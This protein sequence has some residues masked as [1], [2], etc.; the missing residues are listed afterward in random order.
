LSG[1]AEWRSGNPTNFALPPPVLQSMA[2]IVPEPDPC[3]CEGRRYALQRRG[4]AAKTSIQQ[5]GQRRLGVVAM[6]RLVLCFD[7]TWNAVVSPKTVTNVVRL[8]NLVTV[9]DENGIDQITY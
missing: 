9:S 6:K 3:G 1:I 8:A 4:Q 5:F 7:G 2:G